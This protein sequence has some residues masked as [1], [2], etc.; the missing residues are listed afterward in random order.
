MG[1]R[2]YWVSDCVYDGEEVMANLTGAKSKLDLI[3]DR[4]EKNKRE[5]TFD[6][7]DY[8]NS[9]KDKIISAA[10]SR[11]LDASSDGKYIL[12][13]KLE[14]P[15]SHHLTGDVSAK[16]QRAYEDILE[17]GKRYGKRAKEVAARTVRKM[18]SEGK[19]NPGE[20]STDSISEGFHGRPV[21]EHFEIDEEMLYP[22][23]LAVLGCLVELSVTRDGGKTAIPIRGFKLP[24]Q[25]GYQNHSEV[26]VAAPD[27][28]N[29]VFVGGDQEI[30]GAE[31][32]AGEKDKLRLCLGDVDSIVYLTDKHHLVGSN[33]TKE[34]YEHY[35]G[36]KKYFIFGKRVCRPKLVYDTLNKHMELVGGSYTIT[37]EGIKD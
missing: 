5:V 23:D 11:G 22:E 21:K 31:K 8:S 25:V 16:A 37:D 3:L 36:R 33:G 7:R 18:I 35:L 6:V 13:R 10:T 29:I 34:E 14:N 20:S 30:L 4:V 15:G 32:L 27:R 24:G 12:V 1:T 9:Q 2:C 26:Y 17:S 28:N 19:L